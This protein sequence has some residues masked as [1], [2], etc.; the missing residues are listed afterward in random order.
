MFK[1]EYGSVPQVVCL[2][3]VF[4]H[5]GS[6]WY[7]RH[8]QAQSLDKGVD[9]AGM[10]VLLYNMAAATEERTQL[11][12]EVVLVTVGQYLPD[13]REHIKPDRVRELS[14]TVT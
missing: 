2:S 1:D 4:Q 9:R 5:T 13:S 7:C 11:L 12:G 6:D 3:Q 10:A 14:V 8:T